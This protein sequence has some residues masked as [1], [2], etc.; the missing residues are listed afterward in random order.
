MPNLEKTIGL[1]MKTHNSAPRPFK[2]SPDEM[3]DAFLSKY[4]IHHARWLT[5]EIIDRLRRIPVPGTTRIVSDKATV[6]VRTVDYGADELCDLVGQE[7]EVYVG[8]DPRKAYIDDRRRGRQIECTAATIEVGS[9]VSAEEAE[10]IILRRMEGSYDRKKQADSQWAA[11]AN[12]FYEKQV[13]LRKKR[14][15]GAKHA[16]VAPNPEALEGAAEL[17]DKEIK[18]IRA[19]N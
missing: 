19:A 18:S 2:L 4:G 7:V 14:A 11:F 3:C 9:A 13:K 15:A 16:P 10:K 17:T 6:R 5:P 12:A 8:D 1:Y